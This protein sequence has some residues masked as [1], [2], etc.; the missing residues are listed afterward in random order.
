MRFSYRDVAARLEGDDA[1]KLLVASFGWNAN[2]YVGNE[3][4]GGMLAASEGARAACC[5]GVPELGVPDVNPAAFQTSRLH[6]VEKTRLRAD[7]RAPGAAAA[8]AAEPGAPRGAAVPAGARLLAGG[9]VAPSQ[10]KGWFH[11]GNFAYD[12][13]RAGGHDPTWCAWPRMGKKRR[14]GFRAPE[15]RRW[16]L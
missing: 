5:S 16:V 13:E 2:A 6:V 15:R 14:D 12:G 1:G 10:Y 9:G 4:W 3:Y 7:P 8:A 11:G